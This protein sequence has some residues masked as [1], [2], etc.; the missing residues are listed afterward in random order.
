MEDVNIEEV[1]AAAAVAVASTLVDNVQRERRDNVGKVFKYPPPPPFI[2]AVL[3]IQAFVRRRAFLRSFGQPASGDNADEEILELAPPRPL[4]SLAL[5]F[6]RRLKSFRWVN[7]EREATLVAG[8]V[9]GQ[10]ARITMRDVSAVVNY[11]Q[12]KVPKD[13]L[14]LNVLQEALDRQVIVA[15]EALQERASRLHTPVAIVEA[16]EQVIE[17]FQV[18]PEREDRV[19]DQTRLRLKRIVAEAE[20]SLRKALAES[21]TTPAIDA[22]AARY[23]SEF[24]PVASPVE[25]EIKV[26]RLRRVQFLEMELETRWARPF[27]GPLPPHSAAARRYELELGKKNPKVVA[28][29]AEEAAHAATL[30]ADL[31]VELSSLQ[32][33]VRELMKKRMEARARALIQDFDEKLADTFAQIQEVIE[34]AI[35]NIGPDNPKVKKRAEELLS[36]EAMMSLP[37]GTTEGQETA[38]PQP[39][40][41]PVPEASQRAEFPEEFADINLEPPLPPPGEGP[42]GPPV[43][44][45]RPAEK[46]REVLQG[47]RAELDPDL[48]LDDEDAWG[49]PVGFAELVSINDQV[50][51]PKKLELEEEKARISFEPD[52]AQVLHL[53]T[54]AAE[55]DSPEMEQRRAEQEKLERE[56]GEQ[57]ERTA[58]LTLEDLTMDTVAMHTEDVFKLKFIRSIAEALQIPKHRVKVNGFAS[59]SV[60]VLLSILEPTGDEPEDED[61]RSRISADRALEELFAQVED[62]NSRFRLGEVGPFVAAARL[63]RDIIPSAQVN[64]GSM[65]DSYLASNLEGDD[66]ELS[67]PWGE[68]TMDKRPQEAVDSAEQLA[69]TAQ[70]SIGTRWGSSRMEHGSLQAETEFRST[71]PH[72]K[73]DGTLAAWAIPYEKQPMYT[74]YDKSSEQVAKESLVRLPEDKRKVTMTASF[75]LTRHPASGTDTL[76]GKVPPAGGVKV[77]SA[78]TWMDKEHLGMKDPTMRPGDVDLQETLRKKA[79]SDP[80]AQSEEEESSPPPEP[81]T[82]HRPTSAASVSGA[83][84]A[85]SNTRKRKGSKKRKDKKGE[86]SQELSGE[87][88]AT[89]SVQEDSRTD[90]AEGA[91]TGSKT[92]SLDDVEGESEAGRK[93]PSS[94]APKK[95]SGKKKAAGGGAEDMGQTG[96]SFVSGVSA[97]TDDSEADSPKAARKKKPEAAHKAKAKAKDGARRTSETPEVEAPPPVMGSAD[98]EDEVVVPGKETAT[99]KSRASPKRAGRSPKRQVDKGHADG[100]KDLT[101][102]LGDFG[103]SFGTQ[104]CW[105]GMH[106]GMNGTGLRPRWKDNPRLPQL[107]GKPATDDLHTP[108]FVRHAYRHGTVTVGPPYRVTETMDKTSPAWCAVKMLDASIEKA[109]W[110]RTY[111]KILKERDPKLGPDVNIR[112]ASR[113]FSLPKVATRAKPRARP[114]ARSASEDG[115]KDRRASPSRDAAAEQA[116]TQVADAIDTSAGRPSSKTPKPKPE[117]DDK[118]KK[119]DKKKKDKKKGKGDGEEGEDEGKRKKDKKKKEKKKDKGES[120]EVVEPGVEEEV[121]DEASEVGGEPPFELLPS[122]GTWLAPLFLDFE[123]QVATRPETRESSEYQQSVGESDF[124]ATFGTEAVLADDILAAAF[125]GLGIPLE[126]IQVPV[127]KDESATGE[128]SESST[129]I[130]AQAAI[131]HAIQHAAEREA[132]D[133]IP[134]QF[135]PSSGTLMLP[136]PK[137]WETEAASEESRQASRDPTVVSE[138]LPRSEVPAPQQA[139]RDPTVV[140]EHPPGSEAP[141]PASKDP[142]VVS[143]HAAVSEVSEGTA[144]RGAQAAIAHAVLQAARAEEARQSSKAETVASSAPVPPG[145]EGGEV[146]FE[147]LPSVAVSMLPLPI[148]VV[149]PGAATE[150]Y[151][152]PELPR[153]PVKRTPFTNVGAARREVSMFASSLTTSIFR[154]AKQGRRGYRGSSRSPSPALAPPPQPPADGGY[155]QGGPSSDGSAAFAATQQPAEKAHSGGPGPSRHRPAEEPTQQRPSLA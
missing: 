77:F 30:E 95:K 7:V 4:M 110:V 152:L 136:L 42:P 79:I 135:R 129:I 57:K 76:K 116:G 111:S 144:T 86:D 112:V 128:V 2:R 27:V 33:K 97:V 44:T 101:D 40:A 94:K 100:G 113:S 73:E 58:V 143:S 142:T 99:P 145:T 37:L 89:P 59:G 29:V 21:S 55:D 51:D 35:I 26:A 34:K 138:H 63:D 107:V 53:T 127:P 92:G 146:S 126:V 66:F 122:V 18:P 108:C 52:P 19:L 1:R 117:E 123:E 148:K 56:R 23:H 103:D 31:E 139:S 71:C 75:H 147:F 69:Q 15:K 132:L 10:A 24:G 109:D 78:D 155:P 65:A 140:S 83:S 82:P 3:L 102:K 48:E 28:F 119:K 91:E 104:F 25:E 131:V 80:L 62:P 41:E 70:Q 9:D 84:D 12:D 8:L 67:D 137:V 120:G 14:S 93:T 134:L 54:I 22:V 88:Q 60:K 98:A 6:V 96:E 118:K 46:Q 17:E 121:Q 72:S 106:G 149:S 150:V 38:A 153:M 47:G 114:P 154:D 16:M 151:E 74:F 124:S 13:H 43:E 11:Y 141:R 87:G 49:E 105:A 115:K 90:T 5:N 45:Q 68:N 32:K 20:E 85:S 64:V 133:A 50:W 61:G 125:G 39:A 130:G 36:P 81:A